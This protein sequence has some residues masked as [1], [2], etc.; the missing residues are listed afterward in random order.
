MFF[1]EQE[2]L[3]KFWH[4]YVLPRKQVLE[5]AFAARE[6]GKLLP[7][8]PFGFNESYECNNCPRII[9][10][11]AAQSQDVFIDAPEEYDG[12]LPNIEEETL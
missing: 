5:E 6:E 4:H 1:F 8:K 12:D 11:E 10:C 9:M 3:E 2:E 7:P